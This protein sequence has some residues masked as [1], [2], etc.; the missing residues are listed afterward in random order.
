MFQ[1]ASVHSENKTQT[2]MALSNIKEHR[3]ELGLSFYKKDIAANGWHYCIYTNHGVW[4]GAL[5]NSH[6]SRFSNTDKTGSISSFSSIVS[7][8]LD[9]PLMQNLFSE[10]GERCV[11]KID[12]ITVV[13]DMVCKQ[14]NRNTSRLDFYEPLRL[15]ADLKAQICHPVQFC[16]HTVVS[17]LLDICFKV[18][19]SASDKERSTKKQTHSAWNVCHTSTLCSAYRNSFGVYTSGRPITWPLHPGPWWRTRHN[20]PARQW[21]RG[22]LLSWAIL[23]WSATTGSAWIQ[24]STRACTPI[25]E[26][27]TL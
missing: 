10:F 9:V 6:Y 2:L 20:P 4:Y 27:Q 19:R 24:D 22:I 12:D 25:L 11:S 15:F 18:E 7:D 21:H 16:F 14:Q 17:C 3:C 1:W 13:S 5:W 23:R 26:R 8:I